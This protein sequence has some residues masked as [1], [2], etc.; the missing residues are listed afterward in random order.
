[1]TTD[2]LT[3][4]LLE[5]AETIVWAEWMRLLYA[6]SPSQHQFTPTCAELPAARPRPP[7]VATRTA[8]RDR[9]GAP[10]PCYRKQRPAGRRSR[11]PVWPTQR[12]PPPTHHPTSFTSCR[13]T[14]VMSLSDE[15]ERAVTRVPPNSYP[16]Y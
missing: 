3:D 10:R 15:H 4:A 7:Q 11:R 13:P 16:N 9:P 6:T 1:M 5:E 12:S 8:L 14:E 2:T